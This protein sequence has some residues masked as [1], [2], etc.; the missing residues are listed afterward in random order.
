MCYT[1]NCDETNLTTVQ[2]LH[3][4]YLEMFSCPSDE[5]ISLILNYFFFCTPDISDWQHSDFERKPSM[6]WESFEMF[7]I[8][9]L[10]KIGKKTNLLRELFG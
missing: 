9:A 3:I 6:K 8:F 1:I 7:E 5:K 2:T 4:L 10:P